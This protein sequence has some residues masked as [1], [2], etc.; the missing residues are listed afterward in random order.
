MA[1]APRRT[2]KTVDA[3]RAD[4][5]ALAAAG[6]LEQA[7]RILDK[8]IAAKPDYHPAIHQGAVLS[9]RRKRPREALARFLRAV[10]LA[11]DMAAYHRN[12]CEVLRGGGRLDEALAHARRAV[13]LA[14]DD[15]SCHYNLGM[16]LYDRLEIDAAIAAERRALELDPQNAAAHFELSEALLISGRFEEGWREYEWRFAIPGAPR[17]LPPGAPPQWNGRPMPD[18]TLLLIGDQGFG[19]TIQFC[20]Y[21]PEA[22]KLCPDIIVAA[23]AEMRPIVSQ[24]PG[25]RRYH[26]R[27]KD[28]PAFDAWCPLSG[29][30]RLFGAS[31]EKPPPPAPYIRADPGRVAWWREKLGLLLPPGYR[32]I[33]L[34]WAGRPTHGNDFNRSMSLEKCAPLLAL[35]NTAFVSLQMGAAQAQ[36]GRYFGSAPLI[37]L[38]EDFT[39]TMAIL[40]NLD[41]LVAVDTGLAHLAGALG[42]PVSLL[43]SYAPDWRWLMERGDTP[44][45][46]SVTL[47]RQDRPGDWNSALEKAITL[48][49][50]R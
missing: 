27:W 44:W 13:A 50:S 42:R 16:V 20:R 41:R 2:V 8:V 18:G 4:A 14:P 38:A 37:N 11:P 43:L 1:D 36:I 31:L 10:E 25:V 34:A 46:S 39:E 48:I 47:H 9:W 26:A 17:L 32:R 22:A 29:L 21:I 49:R 19:D 23:S 5:E 45:Y 33:G 28:V 3:W 40:E 7:A 6:K 12:I 30:P 24:L 35:E 15:P